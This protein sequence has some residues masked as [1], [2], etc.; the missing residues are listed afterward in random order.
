MNNNIEI[1]DRGI[2][3]QY[4]HCDADVAIY[5]INVSNPKQAICY[6]YSAIKVKSIG[7]KIYITIKILCSTN[8]YVNKK[9]NMKLTFENS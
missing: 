6:H 7:F 5:K 2:V 8:S 4:F 1:F 9:I 3:T